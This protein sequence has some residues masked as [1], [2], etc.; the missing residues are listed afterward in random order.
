MNVRDTK[1][2][3]FARE[4]LHV[5]SPMANE[6]SLR[7][8]KIQRYGH[9]SESFSTPSTIEHINAYIPSPRKRTSDVSQ[10]LAAAIESALGSRLHELKIHSPAY[11]RRLKAERLRTFHRSPNLTSSHDR[12]DAN[13]YLTQGIAKDTSGRSSRPLRSYVYDGGAGGE[14]MSYQMPHSRRVSYSLD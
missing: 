12:F 11:G 4:N 6:Q 10:R 13:G 2:G 7:R 9:G 8:S 3:Q 1:H 14:S 5:S